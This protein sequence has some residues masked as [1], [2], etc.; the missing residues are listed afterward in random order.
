MAAAAAAVVHTIA[1]PPS[2]VKGALCA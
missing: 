1:A 2:I